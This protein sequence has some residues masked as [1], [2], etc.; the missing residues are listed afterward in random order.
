MAYNRYLSWALAQLSFSMPHFK[1]YIHFVWTTKN[2]TPF[3][4]SPELR[5]MVWTHIK[6][7]AKSKDIYID[8]IGGYQDHCHCLV[9]LGSEQTMSKVM[10]LIKGESS[11][12]INK[13]QL[14]KGRFE[15]QEE[16]YAASVSF[17]ALV[18]VREYIISQETHHQKITFNEE[19]E[20]FIDS[21][22][23]ELRGDG[24]VKFG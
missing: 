7:N 2:R 10:Q 17:S 13:N 21:S 3:L 5:S 19:Y 4:N 8:S 24:S 15:W 12:W 1:V 20:N 16:Y 11:F 23:F 6:E 14:C 22:G 9:S 18:N